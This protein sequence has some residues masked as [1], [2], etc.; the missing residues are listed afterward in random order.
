M[1]QLPIITLRHLLIDKSKCIGMQFFPHP[2]LHALVKTLDSVKWS[3]EFSMVYVPNKK[4][5]FHAILAT[6]KGI[7]WLNCR[8]F[9]RNKPVHTNAEATDLSPVRNQIRRANHALQCQVQFPSAYIEHLELKRYSL[10]T[11]RMYTSL[12]SK[13]IQ[14]FKEKD[15]LEISEPDIKDFMHRIVKQ[16]KSAS[17]QNQMINAI[18]F[19]YEQVLDMPQRFYDFGR[20]RKTQKLPTVLSEQEVTRLIDATTNIKHKAILVTIYSCGLR[21]SELINLKITD[22]ESDRSQVFIRGGKGNKDRTTVLSGTTLALLRKYYRQFRPQTYLFEG[23]AGQPYSSS[24]VQHILKQALAAANIKKRASPHTLRHSFATHLLENGTDL[25]YIQTLLGHNSP[26]TT[27]IYAQVSTRS[28]GHVVSPV[29]RL[30]L[31]F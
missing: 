8:Y 3:A 13:F 23:A 16:G 10:N 18:K 4:K 1:N 11:A 14:Y 28:L 5:H 29:D 15:L 19:Y 26:K 30:N 25:R 21:R 17:Y 31:K 7:A 2:T 24:S 27:E 12:F 6:F 20:P 22:I 9:F